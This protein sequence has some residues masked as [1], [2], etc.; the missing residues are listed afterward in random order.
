MKII[1]LSSQGHTGTGVTVDE[2]E[3]AVPDTVSVLL[4]L[5]VCDIEEKIDEISKGLKV[6]V[7]LLLFC[8]V[9]ETVD[10]VSE[11]SRVPVLM[12]LVG[13]V[14]ETVDGVSEG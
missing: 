8:D 4:S 6:P 1:L 13:N 9:E 3:A 5:L 11:G 2:D 14:E 10:G 7:L 12:L